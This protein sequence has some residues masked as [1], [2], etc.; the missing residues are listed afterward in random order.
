VYI[1]VTGAAAL[2]KKFP[3]SGYHHH[4]MM[5]IMPVL[6]QSAYGQ[7]AQTL[8]EQKTEKMVQNPKRTGFVEARFASRQKGNSAL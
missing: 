5:I 6:V 8:A 4:H 1:S 7:S 2:F 3:S